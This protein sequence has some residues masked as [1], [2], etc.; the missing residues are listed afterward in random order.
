M[1]LQLIWPCLLLSP[2]VAPAQ[3]VAPAITE[4]EAHTIGVD[5]YLYLYSL[6]TMDLS[7]SSSRT[8]SRARKSAK[9]R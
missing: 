1:R 3:G 4:A 6:V 8:S 7:R 2:I 9:A 5:A